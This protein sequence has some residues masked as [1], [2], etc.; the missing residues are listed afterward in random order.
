[1]TPIQGFIRTEKLILPTFESL[2]AN[3]HG[4]SSMSVV[5]S[6][7]AAS[8][9]SRY[10]Y[11][12]SKSATCNRPKYIQ[13][14][15]SLTS[16]VRKALQL[17]ASLVRSPVTPTFHPRIEV[18]MATPHITESDTQRVLEALNPNKGASLDELFPKILNLLSPYIAPTLSDIV[19]PSLQTSQIPDDSLI[20]TS[21]AKPPRTADPNLFKSISL[22]S[23]VCKALEAILKDEILAYLSQFSLLT[24]L[25][26]SFLPR[27]SILTNLLMAEELITKWLDERSAVDLIYLDF[28]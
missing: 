28:S 21:V 4:I 10:R 23:V 24:L 12:R 14:Q 7:K 17:L 26:H 25:Q 8:I 2:C 13:M 15:S 19:N 3:L 9:S 11:S 1:M 27:R 16:I 6:R 5:L 18:R 22:T 20:V